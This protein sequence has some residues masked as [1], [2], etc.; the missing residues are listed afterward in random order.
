MVKTTDFEALYND[1]TD[2]CSQSLAWEW[3]EEDISFTATCDC[4]IDY[5]L[6]PITAAM[7]IVKEDEIEED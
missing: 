3:D 1:L 2:C 4:L 6:Q 7:N 5:R